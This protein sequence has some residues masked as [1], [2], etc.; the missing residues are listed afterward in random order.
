MEYKWIG[1][2]LV[3][4]VLLSGIAAAE[5]EG[6][7][8]GAVADAGASGN[9]ENAWSG[10]SATSDGQTANAMAYAA[11]WALAP[12]GSTATAMASVT[13]WASQGGATALAS[14]LVEVMAESGLYAW[15]Q[16]WGISEASDGNAY[17]NANG[18][19]GTGTSLPAGLYPWT[20]PPKHN[21]PNN[22]QVVQEQRGFF[23]YT[24]GKGDFERYCYFKS[25]YFNGST[26]NET[27]PEWWTMDY[28]WGDYQWMRAGDNMIQLAEDR[29]FTPEGFENKM[30]IVEKLKCTSDGDVTTIN[31]DLDNAKK[32]GNG[33][34]G[35][36]KNGK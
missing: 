5:E 2:I 28:N 32:N 31:G 7:S 21:N 8:A 17:A 24:F 9:P 18:V 16:A 13:L 20:D 19:A 11:S 36:H 4:F 26:L 23:G 35:N 15:A 3:L 27:A 12:V 1:A 29:G 33:K 30:K 25:R 14:A 10:A 34:N 6:A 22:G